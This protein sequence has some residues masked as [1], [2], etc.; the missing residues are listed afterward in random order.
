LRKR[1]NNL[2]SFGRDLII[3]MKNLN[4][5]K[6]GEYIEQLNKVYPRLFLSQKGKK[7]KIIKAMNYRLV[8]GNRTKYLVLMDVIY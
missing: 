8:L 1:K 2:L 4:K 3:V 7:R 6:K 5:L